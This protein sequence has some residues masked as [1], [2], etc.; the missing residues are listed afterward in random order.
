M[1]RLAIGLMG[2]GL[3]GVVQ[4]EMFKCTDASG[5]VTFSQTRCAEDAVKLDTAQK[6]STARTEWTLIDQVDKMTGRRQCIIESPG[7]YVGKQGSDFL[8]VSIRV[9]LMDDSRPI[10]AFYSAAPLGDRVEPPSFHNDIHGLGIRI[11]DNPF[12]PVD[13]KAAQRVIGFEEASSE[14]VV[15]LLEAGSEARARVRFWPYDTL[16]DGSPIALSDFPRA[17]ESLRR[18]NAR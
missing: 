5:H 12:V 8:F 2:L 7:S 17:M 6:T 11:D 1:K 10:V 9:T 4:A 3:A 15:A 16:Y 13:R 14:R 18:C